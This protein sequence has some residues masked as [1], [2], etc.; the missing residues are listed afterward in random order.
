MVRGRQALE[1]AHRAQPSLEATML[2]LDHVVRVLLRDMPSGR[3]EFLDEPQVDPARSIT[4]SSR[5]GPKR[6][7]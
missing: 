1:S 3:L 6:S 5:T 7:A 2:G 4:T